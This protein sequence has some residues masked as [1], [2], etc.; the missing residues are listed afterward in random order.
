MYHDKVYLYNLKTTKDNKIVPIVTN[1]I[2][3]DVLKSNFTL[4]EV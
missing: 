2:P 1:E 3:E 4:T